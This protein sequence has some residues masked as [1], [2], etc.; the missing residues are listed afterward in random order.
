MDQDFLLLVEVL[1]EFRIPDFKLRIEDRGSCN[2]SEARHLST[3]R[4]VLSL[5]PGI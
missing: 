1:R 4:A 5:K 3:S 2:K